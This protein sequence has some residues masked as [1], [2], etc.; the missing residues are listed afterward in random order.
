MNTEQNHLPEVEI[1]DRQ[2]TGMNLHPL[3]EAVDTTLGE[4]HCL[5]TVGIHSRHLHH[6]DPGLLS[7]S[8][9]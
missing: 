2:G 6:L 5:L 9:D 7:V 4:A 8:I 1:E 3:M